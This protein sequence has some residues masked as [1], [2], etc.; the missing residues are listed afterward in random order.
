[1]T[2]KQFRNL[3]LS[4][5]IKI[6]HLSYRQFDY[7]YQEYMLYLIL[8][9]Y[10]GDFSI[11]G[12]PVKL[13]IKKDPKKNEY[14]IDRRSPVTLNAELYK[15]YISGYFKND[16]HFIRYVIIVMDKYKNENFTINKLVKITRRKR[17]QY[18][19]CNIS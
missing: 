2:K 10:I 9:K 15:F 13:D 3:L 1:M 19:K 18:E 14:D 5:N 12:M 8:N 4:K 11:L 6:S 16:E 7:R 17:L